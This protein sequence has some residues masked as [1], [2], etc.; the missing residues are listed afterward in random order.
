MAEP[1]LERQA[2]RTAVA[3]LVGGVTVLLSSTAVSIALHA[4]VGDLGVG[5]A[6]VHW[7][8]TAYLLAL[9]VVIPAVG[10]LQVRC[11]ARRLW[12]AALGVFLLGSVLCA[13]AWDLHSLIAFRVIQGAGAGVATPLLTTILMQRSTER[14]RVR[15]TSLVALATTVGPILGPVIG[16]L[17]LAA[18]SWRWLFVM[19]VPLC[20][21]ALHLARRLIPADG[22]AARRPRFD[23]VGAVL[24]PPALVALL[25]GLS[26]VAGAGSAATPGVLAPVLAGAGLLGAFV[27][28]AHRRRGE[29]LVDLRVMRSRAT[30]SATAM[31]FLAGAAL[32]GAMML[33]PLYWQQARGAG[34]VEAGLL[35]VPQGIGSLVSRAVVVRIVRRRGA[36]VAA[37][38][39]FALTGLA[40]VPFA[41]VGPGDPSG[42]DATRWLLVGALLL[43]GLGIGMVVVPLMTVVFAGVDHD[44]V[45]HASI[46]ARIGQQV[47]G[48]AGVALLSVVLVS[49]AG[50]GGPAAPG[51]TVAFWWTAGIA[52]L[53]TILSA[54]LPAGSARRR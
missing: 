39:G 32:H 9:C 1:P 53:A 18:G 20:I 42:A 6:A 41:L 31:L 45:P 36:R 14:D 26:N 17:V 44:Q 30:A 15:L 33:L 46:V 48:S 4:L 12:S 25:W 8:I 34:P 23:I 21:L 27:L 24:L 19:N 38:V 49:A 50:T 43:R 3:V 29:A 28:W 5:V 54:S 51:F 35:L 10:W 52:A 47:G 16:G 40:T 13:L 37:V 11:G 7:V 22:P 2:L